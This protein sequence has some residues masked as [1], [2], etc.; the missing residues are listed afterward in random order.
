MTFPPITIIGAG[1]M[2]SHILQGLKRAGVDL[3]NICVT[4]HDATKRETLAAQF[5]VK[6]QENNQSAIAQGEIIILAIKPQSLHD[7][8]TENRAAFSHHPLVI[9]IAAG[10]SCEY[11]QTLF[12]DAQNI[13]RA[14]PNV[15]VSVSQGNTILFTTPLVSAEKRKLADEIFSHLGLT[16]WVMDE[17]QFDAYTILTGAGP[18]Y[19]FFILQCIINAAVQLGIPQDAAKEAALQLF[20]GAAHM[21]ANSD[22]T[23]SELQQQVTSKNGVTEKILTTLVA[24]DFEQLF[25]QAFKNAYAHGQQLQHLR[26]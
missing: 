4:D 9:S 16:Q 25:E 11:L 10:I 8:A 14:M 22:N 26:K 21:A 5:G 3:D 2:A 24:G 23:L 17:K 1:N 19:V 12:G 18:G 13:I 20:S 6:T 7:F 15:C